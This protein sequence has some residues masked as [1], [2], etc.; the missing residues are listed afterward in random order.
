MIAATT[1]KTGVK[2][3]CE[4][5]NNSYPK[6]VVVSNDEMARLNIQRADFHGEWNYAIG[7]SNQASQALIS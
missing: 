7:S 3:Y 1:T 5:D 2:V 6:G 4:L